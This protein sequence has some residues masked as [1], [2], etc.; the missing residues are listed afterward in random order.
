MR[1]RCHETRAD[2][3]IRLGFARSDDVPTLWDGQL[4]RYQV[5]R[6]AV[7]SALHRVLAASRQIE[8]QP[9]IR[10]VIRTLRCPDRY[11]A[12]PAE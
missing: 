12:R 6:K 5:H 4:G 11:C 9:L 2:N 7:T 1:R 3:R 10:D 8:E